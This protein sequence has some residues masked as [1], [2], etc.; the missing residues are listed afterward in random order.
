M[1]KAILFDLDGTIAH[2]DTIHFSIWQSWLQKYG[3]NIDLSFYQ[4]NINGRHNQDFLRQWLSEL[5]EEEIQQF[6]N[7]KEAYFREIAQD[8]LRPLMGLSTLLNWLRD[9]QLKSAVVTNAPRANADF[10]LK[11]LKLHD[12]W[13]TVIVG[14]E[15][16]KAKPDPYPYQ[17]ALRCLNIAP[18]EALVF[19]DSPTGIY[20]SVGAGIFTV[21]ISTTHS[22]RVL[23]ECGAKLIIHDFSDPRLK[24]IGVLNNI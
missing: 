9:C 11:A 8:Q 10:M 16:P 17:E 12:F 7:D 20:S 4:Q 13:E 2:T 15:L 14:E 18:D 1:L 5:S 23:S 19:E 3:L 22:D 21:G 24:T 6:S